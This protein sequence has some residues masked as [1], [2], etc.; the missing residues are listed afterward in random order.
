MVQMQSVLHNRAFERMKEI[1]ASMK[2]DKDVIER[3]AQLALPG[4]FKSVSLKSLVISFREAKKKSGAKFENNEYV[5]LR[6]LCLKF[7]PLKV[8]EMIPRFFLNFPVEK[9][10]ADVFE[11][12]MKDNLLN[13][14]E[15]GPTGRA[16]RVGQAMRAKRADS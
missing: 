3:D 13:K 4:E 6:R 15:N 11:R 9:Q 1:V 14:G 8:A 2:T 12:Y 16:K 10:K 5:V 7:S